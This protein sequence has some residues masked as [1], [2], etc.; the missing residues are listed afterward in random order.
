MTPRM[1]REMVLGVLTMLGG[2]VAVYS[3]FETVVAM[4]SI[5]NLEWKTF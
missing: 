1:K 5:R 3:G 4:W 2:A